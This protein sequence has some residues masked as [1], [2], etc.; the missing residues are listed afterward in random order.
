VPIEIRQI[1]VRSLADYGRIPIAFRVES[2]LRLDLIDR[3]LG[4]I[5]LVE[6]C[7]PN[8]YVKNYDAYEDGG[9]ERWLARFEMTNW[10]IFVAVIDDLWVGGAVVAYKTP[11]VYM[12]ADRQD[13]AVL[14]D[15]RI[16]TE[17]RRQ[18]IG[19]E[20]FQHAA[21]WAGKKGCSQLK[22]ETQNINVP[23]CR[24]YA[25]QG[26]ILGGIDLFAYRADPRIGDEVM[27][28][29]YLDL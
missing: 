1:G 10:G 14:W 12:L 3:G 28:L 16:R 9:P 20:L 7:V 2:R 25:K 23:A 5:Q 6:E 19:T 15:L 24:F 22:I 21:L 13:L 8:P 26:C 4:G 11:G 18:G 29:F 27:F 17:L